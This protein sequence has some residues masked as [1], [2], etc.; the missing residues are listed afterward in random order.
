[1]KPTLSLPGRAVS[2]PTD[3]KRD[4]NGRRA[5]GKIEVDLRDWRPKAKASV[6]DDDVDERA[7]RRAL[8]VD[9][10]RAR[11]NRGDAH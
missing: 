5:D 1:M 10:W 7:A 2:P 3:F 8:G 4:K 11:R 9:E 6:A